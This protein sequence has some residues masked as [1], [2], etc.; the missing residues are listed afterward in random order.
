MP[1]AV[2]ALFARCDALCL[3][4]NHNVEMLVNGPYPASLKARIRG[5]RGH[6][7]NATSGKLAASLLHAGLRAL[8]LLHLSETNNTPE[9]AE[10]EVDAIVRKAGFRGALRAAPGRTPGAAF[11]LSEAAPSQLALAL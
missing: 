3:E 2:R 1:D 6:I 4:A 8:T 9:Q 5:G 11:T 10:R 7:D